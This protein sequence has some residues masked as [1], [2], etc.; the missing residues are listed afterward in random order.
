MSWVLTNN[1]HLNKNFWKECIQNLEN[2]LY[3]ICAQQKI[4]FLF[5]IPLKPSFFTVNTINTTSSANTSSLAVYPCNCCLTP[6]MCPQ[7]LNFYVA[8]NKTLAIE[9]LISFPQQS[10][11]FYLNF[12][13]S[14]NFCPKFSEQ[15]LLIATCFL[16]ASVTFISCQKLKCSSSSLT[17]RTI[18]T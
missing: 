16:S 13:I 9:R 3:T 7:F 14:S 18:L 17:H 2:L 15:I 11:F 1:L 12:S 4:W 5:T 8:A 6:V 10:L